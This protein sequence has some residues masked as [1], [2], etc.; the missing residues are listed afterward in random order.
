MTDIWWLIP[1]LFCIA[2]A[3]SSVGLG[4]GSSYV[5]ILYLFGLPLAKIPPI[6]LFFNITAA[7][8]AVYRFGRQGYIRPR[9]TLPF[10]AASVPATFLA[11]RWHPHDA[12]LSL[13]MGVVLVCVAL[14]LFFKKQEVKPR[15]S[16]E[17]KGFFVLAF[18]LGALMGALAGVMG[19]GGG[20]FLGPAML[21][22]GLASAKHVAGTCSA[23][24]LVNS[25][26]GLSSHYIQGRVDVTAL[27]A[28][29]IAV[30]AGAQVGSFLGTRKLSPLVLQRIFG[31]FLLIVGLR[32]GMEILQ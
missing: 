7:S 23:F 22:A 26:V 10:L 1:A 13:I 24:V 4:G 9:L 21:L 29:G 16:L 12:T 18:G 2:L 17:E 30:F 25:A 8:V 27:L 5:A 14:V 31:M 6:V 3:Y 11:A 19:I 20:V 28:L 32:L 15:F